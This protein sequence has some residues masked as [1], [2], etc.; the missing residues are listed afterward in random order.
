MPDPTIISRDP[1]QRAKAD[2]EAKY[3]SWQPL[4]PT[5]SVCLASSLF[6]VA[7]AIIGAVGTGSEPAR[8]LE[9]IPVVIGAA[10]LLTYFYESHLLRKKLRLIDQR[11]QMLSAETARLRE[12]CNRSWQGLVAQKQA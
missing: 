10:T 5:L 1:F 12:T 7:V 9:A 3:G 8:A 11:W 4:R 2:A 6:G